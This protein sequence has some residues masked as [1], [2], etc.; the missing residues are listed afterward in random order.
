MNEWVSRE[1]TG[2]ERKREVKWFAF[3]AVT[4]DNGDI[5]QHGIL[6][7]QCLTCLTPKSC[8]TLCS[9][10]D[11]SLPGSSVRGISQARVL[12]WVANSFSRG[13]SP[14]RDQT[15]VSCVGRQSLYL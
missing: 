14:P 7:L 8:L 11:R 13:S 6:W 5:K 15:W 4:T 2:N 3:G 10:V 12:E 1:E 9:P